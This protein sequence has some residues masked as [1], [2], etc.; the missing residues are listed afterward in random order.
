MRKTLPAAA[1]VVLIVLDAAPASADTGFP[2]LDGFT[3]VDA[4]PYQRSFDWLGYS[5]GYQFTSP[6]GYRC[7][8]EWIAKSAPPADGYCWGTLPGT[9]DNTVYFSPLKPALFRNDDLAKKDDTTYYNPKQRRGYDEAKFTL[10]DYPL[11]PAG[12][13]ITTEYTGITCAV[14]ADTTACVTNTTDTE[15]RHGFVLS[16]DGNL[17]F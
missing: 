1:A 7:R 9:T 15:R 2:D 17:L 16:P 3:A 12:S 13:K 5:G 10:A 14:T 6:R 8:V 11:L 4:T